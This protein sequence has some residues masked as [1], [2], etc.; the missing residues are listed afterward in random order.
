MTTPPLGVYLHIPFCRQRCDFC[1]F[2]LEIHRE[3]RAEA[4]VR[5]LLHEIR[6]STQQHV[7]VGRPIQ[8]VYL[9][10]G[11]PTVLAAAQLVAILSEIRSALALASDCEITVEAHPS[12]I[13][14]QDLAQL[15]QAGTTRISFGA[16]SMDDG[17]L[18]RIGRPGAVCETVTAV[19]QARAAGFT[20]I[21]LDVMYGLPG[22]SLASWQRTLTHCLTLEPTHLSCYA[23]T[24]EEGTRLASNIQRQQSPALDEGLQIEMDEAAQQL[25]SDAGY[26]RYEVSNYAKPGYACRHNLLYWTNGEYLGF[27]PSAQSYLD[28]TRFGNIADLAVYNTSL[29]E[30]RLPIEDRSRLSEKEQ[31]RDAVIFGLRLIR[32]VPTFHLHQHAENYGHSAVTAQ[33]LAEQLIEEDG[34][35]SRLSARGRLQ[36]D[37]IAG[38][39]Y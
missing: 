32:G 37:T 24:I 16:E 20:N 36:A 21:N 34:A 26:E 13:S 38:Q 5:S 30:N 10:G 15:H 8:S 17:D 28:G 6:L 1:A 2:Y 33:L 31:L 25:L 4:F 9:G 22:Q 7:A 18:T 19:T 35:R 27:G 3:G 29:A 23:L 11:T 12:T 39:L 14:E